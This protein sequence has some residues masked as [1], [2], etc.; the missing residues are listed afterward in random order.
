MTA[1]DRGPPTERKEKYAG[2]KLVAKSSERSG[3]LQCCFTTSA[4]RAAIRANLTRRM[5]TIGS[6]LSFT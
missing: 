1:F 6:S 4:A 3:T 2:C 5:P